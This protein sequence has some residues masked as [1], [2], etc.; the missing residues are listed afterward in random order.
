MRKI[1][2]SDII[3]TG[4][5]AFSMF[6]G[7]GNVVFPL[8]IGKL[9][10]SN[11]PLALFGFLVTAVGLPFL[12]LAAMSYFEG[13]YE[14]FFFRIGKTPGLIF[15][16]AIMGLIGPFAA[17]PRLIVV[18]YAALKMYIPNISLMAFSFIAALIIFGFTVKKSR[19]LES[20]GNILSPVL[21]IS[22][23]VIIFKGFAFP[24]A[25]A[26]AAANGSYFLEGLVFGYNT[27][28]L[29]ASI[30][31]STVILSLL[32]IKMIEK[33]SQT[34]PR[35]L[36]LKVLQS[37]AIAA[38]LLGLVYVGLGFVAAARASTLS[39]IPSDE[40]LSTLSY[41]LL[42]SVGGIIA[43]V[44]VA[45]ACLTTAITLAYVFADFLR[46]AMK[47]EI[48]P[49]KLKVAQQKTQYVLPLILTLIITTIFANFGF[50]GIMNMLV[51]VL[52][53]LYPA[54]IVLTLCN[55]AYKIYG[56]QVVKTPVYLTLVIS[57]ILQ[58][59]PYL[60]NLG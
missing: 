55:L 13:D 42:G 3:T 2:S 46:A 15:I 38:S 32:K 44:A 10:G 35:S 43:S 8:I 33:G 11:T 50:D 40:I 54:L 5:A 37:G 4:L 17:M 26:S 53:V 23:G 25:S 56:F 16:Y 9:S 27:M 18:S 58:A 12:G 47:M 20:L 28:D 45:L 59:M 36:A 7:A 34:T 39:G 31:F 19:I 24:E 60:R 14:S 1:F 22:L 21:L 51:P 49:G 6:F 48:R 29:F 41:D 57:I 52:S 30:F